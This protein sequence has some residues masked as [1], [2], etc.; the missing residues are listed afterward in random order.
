MGITDSNPGVW[1]PLDDLTKAR[2]SIDLA[3]SKIHEGHH[4][5]VTYALPLSVGS[6]I[7]MTVNAPASAT[8]Y[9]HFTTACE[10]PN[11]GT[12][13]FSELPGASAGSDLAAIVFNS[14]RGSTTTAIAS[15]AG[16]I[17]YESSG[18]ILE[19]H[20]TSTTNSAIRLGGGTMPRFE[21][22]LKP[23]TLYLVRWLNTAAVTANTV[24]NASFYY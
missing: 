6:A 19:T 17:T 23:S 21:Y 20:Y 12:F 22:I 1:L 3:H 14:Q 10:A 5:T 18:T 2:E 9:I 11:I 16:T 4:F 8:G 13:T 15:I 7:T 24:I